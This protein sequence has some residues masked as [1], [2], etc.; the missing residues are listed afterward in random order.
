MVRPGTFET[1]GSWWHRPRVDEHLSARRKAR[2]AGLLVVAVA[3][4]PL[5]LATP[6]VAA[7]DDV[8]VL[9]D[10]FEETL[11]SWRAHGPASVDLAPLGHESASSML[12]ADRSESWHGAETDVVGLLAPGGTYTV[13][14]WVRLAAGEVDTEVKITVAETPAAYTTVAAPVVATDDAWVE[15][16]GTYTMPAALTAGALYLEA[17]G[18]ETSFMV[19]DVQITGPALSDGGDDGDAVVPGGAV[20]P[21]TT[22]LATAQ[23]TGDVAALTFDDGPNGADTTALLDY[24]AEQEIAATFCVIGQ[25]IEA[26]GG[27][28]ILRRI[29]ADGHTLCNHTT[30]YTDMGSWSAEQVRADLVENLEI[31]RTAL[32]DPTAAVPYFRAPNGSWGQTPAVAV[33]LGMQPLAVVNTINDWATQD[34]A[35]LESNLRTAMKPGQIVLAHDGGGDRSGTVAAIKTVVG[36]K[37][38]AGWS[39]TQ[40]G[41]PDA[42]AGGGGSVSVG[43]DNDFE[44][45]L[46][47]WEPRGDNTVELDADAHGGAQAALV[48]GR[49]Q[50][51]NGIA[52]DVTGIFEP[53]SSYSISAWVKLAATADPATADLRLSIQRD[54]AGQDTAYDTITSIPGVTATTWTRVQVDYT[55]AAAD[56]ALLYL[57]SA[58]ALSDFLV[59]DIVVTTSAREVQTDI[60]SLKDELPWPVGVAIDARETVDPSSQLVTKHFEQITA[61]NAMKPE[62]VQPTEGVFTFDLA[63]QLVDYAVAND[64]RVYGHTLVWHS[65]TPDWFFADA[66]GVPLTNSAEHQAILRAR[67]KTHIETVADHYRDTYGEFGTA[68]NPVVAFDVVNEAIDES[69]TD[70]L[71]RS[72][73]FDVLGESYLDLAYGYA[74]E[75]FN[76]G[77]LDGPVRLFLN[78]YNTE[79]PAKRAAML[80]VVQ[81]M[82]ARG[83]PINGVGHQLHVSLVTP[84]AQI[85]ATIDAFETTGLLQAVTELDVAFDG[86]VTEERLTEQ[87]YYFA[88]LFDVLREYPDLFSV[89]VWGLYDSRSWIEGAPLVFDDA[90]QA[91]PA[92]WGIVD[93]S[94]LPALTRRVLAHAADVVIG[95][96]TLDALEWDLLPLTTI[97]SDDSGTTGFQLRWAPDRV[98]VYAEVVDPTDDGAQDT[99]AFFAGD[100]SVTVARDGST[101]GTVVRSTATG[102]TV[103]AEVPVAGLVPGGSV[104]VD[105]RV[106]DGATGD[107]LSW[108]DLSHQQESGDALGTAALIEPVGYVGISRAAA[109]VTVDAVIEAAWADAPVVSTDTQVEGTDGASAQVRTLWSDGALHILAEVTD[110]S[111]D[112]TASNAWER[113]SIELFLDPTNAKSGAYNP[114]DGQ[115]R[116]SYENAQSIDGDRT[117]IGENLTSATRVTETGY[118]VEATLLLSGSQTA[119]MAAAAAEGSFIGF[120][121]QV[122]DATAGVRTSVRS[123][124]DPTGR[125][126]QDTSR[127]GVGQLLAADVVVPPGTDPVLV[128]GP[129]PSDPGAQGPGA[130]PGSTPRTAA[131][132]NGLALTGASVAL[133]VLLAGGLVAGG[134]FLIRRRAQS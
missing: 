71:R 96:D 83:V 78:D 8:V 14:A 99:L 40:P 128:P 82:Q 45:D 17:T 89:T 57:E 51:W 21:T 63:D 38:A 28:E 20:N 77:D 124:T 19:D 33:A 5:A 75:A 115:Y 25:N 129:V 32:G 118:V 41:A 56:S 72:R 84:I 24:L 60:P 88:D 92:Y 11:G 101:A 31:I 7:P 16:T 108:N 117:V 64:L 52:A 9:A 6:S 93:R 13:S 49:T 70:G 61:E 30:G 36:E 119:A 23:G 29:V 15:L 37:L 4:A 73:W 55:M 43:L 35:T 134:T 12:V 66:A 123:W 10:D 46:G 67:M 69:E 39:F 109:P 125:G 3:A 100:A 76:G 50:A 47:A 112:A 91:K 22:P 95:P 133:L 114:A 79:Q 27:A 86:E 85:Q 48:A 18:A 74:S 65:Q 54:I 104:P 121:V 126:Y 1:F 53:E 59:D 105:I 81:R 120:D 62:A 98:T 110:A 80:D 44:T 107:Q 68:G 90:L 122:N 132:S 97:A 130:A 113:D 42:P 127:W 131:A 102:Y 116:I 34:V 103:V 106:T 26:P 58:S 111:L 94:E 2:A 87:G